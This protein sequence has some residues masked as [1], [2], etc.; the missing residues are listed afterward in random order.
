MSAGFYGVLSDVIL[1]VHFAFVAF[2]IVGFG[3]VWIGYFCRWGFVHNFRFRLAHMLAMGFVVAESL[4][5]MVCPLTTW[6]N[7]LRRRAGEGAAY[8]ESFIE[9]WLGQVLYYDVSAQAFTAIYTGFF[10]LVVVTYIVIPP[11]RSR[12]YEVR[13][14]GK[15]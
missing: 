3:I 1:V 5:G 14:G 7:E 11:R 13:P 4:V 10:V 15:L 6:E 8:R 2:I 9:H 12:K